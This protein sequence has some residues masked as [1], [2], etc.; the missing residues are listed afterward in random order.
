MAD[1]TIKKLPKPQLRG[2]LHSYIRKHGIIAA[3]LCTISVFAVKFGV[4]DRRKQR[5]ADFYKNYDAD[6]VFEE[7]RKKNL[8]Q[9][10]PWPEK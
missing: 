8:F 1:T 9:S 4:A 10:A 2:L 6:A 5:Y 3:V 7:M